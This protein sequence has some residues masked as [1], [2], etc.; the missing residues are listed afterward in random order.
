MELKR[1]RYCLQEKPKE[2]FGQA[3]TINGKV[4]RR[5]RC[6][7]CKN[8]LQ[9]L[10][11][12]KIRIWLRAYKSSLACERCGFSDYRALTFHHRERSEKDFNVSD[13][14]GSGNSLL[15]VQ[16]EIAKCNILCANCHSI[17]HY[18][19]VILDSNGV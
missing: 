12:Q 14:I 18:Q 13:M 6:A 8:K 5:H 9:A 15:N 19:E 7:E 17:E 10:R 16:R 11:K 1:C 2:N 3:A 4:Y